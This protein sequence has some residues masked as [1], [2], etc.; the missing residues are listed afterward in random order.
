M[1]IW[2]QSYSAIGFDPRWKNY[3]DTLKRNIK[4][5]ARPDTKVDLFGVEKISPKMIESDYIQYLHV[6]QV[7]EKGLKAE[8]EG[9][10]AFIVG[11]TLDPG[12]VYVRELL[13]IPVA[14]IGESSF[15]TACLLAPKFSV[16]A[17][18][19]ALLRRQTRLVES[20]GLGQRFVPGAHL[21]KTNQ[22]ELVNEMGKN[23]KSVIE[24]ITKA[25]SKP[26]EQGAGALVPG[27]G[28]ITSFLA[29]QGIREI[30]GVPIVDGI[31]VVIKTAEMLVDLSKMGIKRGK[32]G[33][34]IS[35]VAKAELMAARKFYGVE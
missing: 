13:D 32:K 6:A 24:M 27:F 16:I 4:E 3:E 33:L 28:A 20:Y 26:I 15:Y 12:A 18:D 30:E 34:D 17:S 29:D 11:G 8:R 14:F 10:D 9:Y 35:P 7:I 2:Y 25:A 31:A 1:K 22:L 21:S 5:V 19:G 23:P